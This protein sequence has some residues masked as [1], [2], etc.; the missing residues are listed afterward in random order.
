MDINGSLTTSAVYNEEA[1]TN[2]LNLDERRLLWKCD[3]R[4]LPILFC[5]LVMS[6]L[7]KRSDDVHSWKTRLSANRLDRV[8]IG[9]A[10]IQGLE[11]D[12]HMKGHD[13]NV[14]LFVLFI[15]LVSYSF[16]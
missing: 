8:N 15:P 1:P 14:A 16:S 10:K 11:E 3:L 2:R 9:N 5:S 4:I 7:G 6:F 13:Y 12:L